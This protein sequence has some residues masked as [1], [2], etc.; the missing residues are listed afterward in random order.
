MF[1]LQRTFVIPCSIKRF[2]SQLHSISF[3]SRAGNPETESSNSV[4]Q[5]EENQDGVH[6]HSTPGVREGVPKQPIPLTT[7]ADPDRRH[8]G[9]NRETGEDLVPE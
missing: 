7:A 3:S 5:I 4:W 1:L 2:V 9:P 6:E 8:A